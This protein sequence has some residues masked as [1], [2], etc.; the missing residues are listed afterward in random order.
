[1]FYWLIFVGGTE[2]GGEEDVGENV[3]AKFEMVKRLRKEGEINVS[4]KKTIQG[5]RK[6]QKL[7]FIITRK[8]YE[9]YLCKAFFVCVCV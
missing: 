2:E 7:V 4:E 1:M 9:V 8:V 5:S 3:Y 6:W